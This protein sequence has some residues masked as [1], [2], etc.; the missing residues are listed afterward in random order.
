MSRRKR[1]VLCT[2][3]VPDERDGAS[4][5]IIHN[6]IAPIR[7][8]DVDVL[9][10]VLLDADPKSEEACDA[11]RAAAGN[12][13]F[14]IVVA[15]P[16]KLV[17]QGA[18]SHRLNRAGTED[19]HAAANAF[20]ADLV[21]AFD[22][23]P[24]WFATTITAPRKL[25]WLGD[26][27]FETTYYHGLYNLQE[28]PWQIV[29][30]AKYWLAARNWRRVYADVLAQFDEVLVSAASSVKQIAGLGLSNHSYRPYPW[31]VNDAP[32][33]PH[34]KPAVPTFMF[35]GN[36]VGLGSRSAL[37]FMIAK[38]YPKLIRHWGPNGFRILIAGRGNIPSW[39]ASAIADKPEFVQVGFVE[40]LPA[41]L[42]ACHGVLVPI[43]VPVGNRT[44]VLYAMSQGALVI[45]HRNVALGNP[46]LVDDQTAALAGDGDA[47]V[48]RMRRAFEDEAWA[49]RI[50]EAGQRAYRENF[51]PDRAAGDFMARVTSHLVAPR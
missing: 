37:H 20:Q 14:Q 31:P 1:I 5:V 8:A 26:L 12:D 32:V 43:D 9:H 41:T 49:R 22:I 45:A 2:F 46:A 21:I 3:G 42:M 18:T 23:L 38:A 4:L 40:D 28:H 36:L 17:T 47:F 50:G 15:R 51:H 48:A 34:A 24:A 10:V 27:N 13:H 19:A 44:R 16:A 35:F 29:T 33:A 6:F 39:F 7:H 11:Y 30:F 25:V